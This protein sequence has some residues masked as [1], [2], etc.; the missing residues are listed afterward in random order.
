MIKKLQESHVYDEWYLGDKEMYLDLPYYHSCYYP[1][2][3]EILKQIKRQ[4]IHLV[5]EVGCGNGALAELLLEKANIKYRG[6]DF[7]PVAIEK[8]ITRTGHSELFYIAD[9][10][11][12]ESYDLFYDGIIC[13]EVLEHIEQ[14]LEVIQN[15]QTGITCICS[16]PNFDSDYHT[17]YFRTKQE[18]VDRY[19]ELIDIDEII[20]IKKPVLSN[21]SWK[22]YLRELRWNRY[23]P[24]RLLEIIG[25]GSFDKVGGWFLFSGRRR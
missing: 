25:L 24:R 22:N 10:T 2:F 13:T 15:W 12:P 1:L 17:R 7:S 14:D 3:K 11:L 6:F 23:R 9:A 8:A 20:M 5:L 16:V 18:V 21:I 19:G 4:G